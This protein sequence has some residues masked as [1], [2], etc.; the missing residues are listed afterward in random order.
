MSVI[1]T[2]RRIEPVLS[3]VCLLRAKQTSMLRMRA[4]PLVDDGREMPG[5]FSLVSI[6]PPE[7]RRAT[8]RKNPDR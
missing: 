5:R 3:G 8:G 7:E 2:K 6:P 4:D 1:G